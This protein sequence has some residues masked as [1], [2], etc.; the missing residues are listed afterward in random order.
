VAIDGGEWV[1][2]IATDDFITHGKA[3]PDFDGIADS[4]VDH[5]FTHTGKPYIVVLIPAYNE[6]LTI[7]SVVLQA[8]RH[9]NVVLVVNDGSKDRT[10]EVARAAGAEVID[11]LRNGGKA[12]A[13]RIG[14]NELKKRDHDVVVMMDGDGQHDVRDINALITP[15]L[16]N[17]ADLTIGSRF[18]KKDNS[19]PLYRQ[20]GQRILN[21]MTNIGSSKK[22]TDT[23]SGFRAF[24]RKTLLNMNF[25]STGYAVEQ[26]MIIHCSDSGLRITEVPISVRYDV[27]NGH[28]QGSLRMGMGLLNSIISTIGYK[29]PL[30]LFGVPGFVFFSAGLVMGVITLL[31]V[32]SIG[33]WVLQSLMAGFMIIVGTT[34]V[35]SALSLNSLSLMMKANKSTR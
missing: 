7:G 24:N 9:A 19:I 31:D 21:R 12:S 33:T 22:V 2:P 3:D 15:I 32:F 20:V 34:L 18:M 23:Q 6:E 4:V 30:L 25:Q 13:L 26:D 5:I 10:S 1:Q 29:R 11:C 35:V 14:F 8:R 16:E 28:K 27:P 17:E